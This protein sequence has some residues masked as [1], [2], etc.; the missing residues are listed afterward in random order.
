M[1]SRLEP[2][3]LGFR[4]E[5]G[6]R[7]TARQRRQRVF[8]VASVWKV[9]AQRLQVMVV[10]TATIIAPF[11]P[12]ER[13]LIRRS[14]GLRCPGSCDPARSRPGHLCTRLCG[15]GS[16]WTGGLDDQGAT[17]CCLSRT[18]YGK[19]CRSSSQ[20]QRGRRAQLLGWWRLTPVT[21]TNYRTANDMVRANA[22]DLRSRRMLG[23]T[24]GT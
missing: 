7:T 13:R 6:T 9:N 16:R 12:S 17:D 11:R 8:V 18:R 1:C 19:R 10:V 5:A 21:G 14:E 15:S 20:W 2:E 4:A 23:R 24:L 3:P 22:A